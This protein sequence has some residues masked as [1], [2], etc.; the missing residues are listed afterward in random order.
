MTAFLTSSSFALIGAFVVASLLLGAG[1]DWVR[2]QQ[3]RDRHKVPAPDADKTSYAGNEHVARR[4]LE[5]LADYAFIQSEA[6]RPDDS[7]DGDLDLDI[8]A[9]PDLFFALERAFGI[10]CHVD[11]FEVFEATTAGLDS[12]SDVI[13]YVS[14][15]VSE[16]RS[17]PAPSKRPERRIDGIE[18]IAI[19]WF[20]GL[21]TMIA[22]ALMQGQRIM[23][24]G[25]VIA[26]LPLT[27]GL[28]RV[29]VHVFRDLVRDFQEL[30]TRDMLRYPL[31]IIGWLVVAGLMLFVFA[32]FCLLLLNAFSAGPG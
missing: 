9:N 8:S 28:G 22:G 1:T 14:G 26:F 2:R 4:V 25:L 31:A 11:K 19:S 5:V 10:D 24:A 16:A 30:G 21:A 27:Y 15:K 29:L 7:L 23:L 20:A 6:I 3:V 17:K 13:A 32:A 12:V 18:I